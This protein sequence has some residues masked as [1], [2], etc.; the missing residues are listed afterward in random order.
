M[1]HLLILEIVKTFVIGVAKML[2]Q[3]PNQNQFDAMVSLAF[4][5]GLGNF[6]K[7]SVLKKFN[8][9]PNDKT[10]E[11]SFNLWNKGGGKVLAGLTIRRVAEAKLYFK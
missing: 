1:V 6:K 9:D 2:K 11:D 5:I 8:L 7:S 10:I 3:K 4:N